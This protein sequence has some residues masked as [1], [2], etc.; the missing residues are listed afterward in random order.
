M[1]KV[2]AYPFLELKVWQNGI[3]CVNFGYNYDAVIFT[4][5]TAAKF[6]QCYKNFIENLCNFDNWTGRNAVLLDNC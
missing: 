6:V 3:F 2:K 1:D 4:F 5:S